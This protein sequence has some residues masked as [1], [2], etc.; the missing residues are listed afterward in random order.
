[1]SVCGM[2]A[3]KP[4][5][6]LDSV[7]EV[8]ACMYRSDWASLTLATVDWL[9]H[10]SRLPVIHYSQYNV[11]SNV[12]SIVQAASDTEQPAHTVPGRRL[13]RPGNPHHQAARC[14][15]HF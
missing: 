12:A 6:D 14:Y 1:M 4:V 9:V 11:A 10:L 8:P 7:V 2:Y 13:H 15:L 3:L 5:F